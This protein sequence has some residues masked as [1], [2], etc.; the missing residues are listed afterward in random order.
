MKRS[1]TIL[2]VCL[3][4]TGCAEMK[5][6]DFANTEP[7]FDLYEYFEGQTVAW[8]LFEDRFGKVRR[9]FKVEITGTVDQNDGQEVLVLD[10]HFTYADGEKD[11]RVWTINREGSQNYTG[12]ADDIIGQATGTS[13]GNALNWSYEMDLPVGSR[14][15]RVHFNDWMFLQQDG[16]MINRAK[17]TKF[18]LDIGEVSLFFQK[19]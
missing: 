17:V 7:K 12:K 19:Q 1:A 9:Q 3:L 15:I 11:R 10:E 4:L 5:P 6:D 14:K 2:G 8:G 18:G 16:V 13:A